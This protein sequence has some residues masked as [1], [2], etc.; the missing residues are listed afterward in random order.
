MKRKSKPEVI[1]SK[2]RVLQG[3]SICEA[4]IWYNQGAVLVVAD[5]SIHTKTV[6]LGKDKVAVVSCVEAADDAEV[7]APEG[8][9]P[10]A[11]EAPAMPNVPE[12]STQEE[13]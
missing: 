4:G 3:C 6:P 11:V 13:V 9:L 10:I 2:V 1:M 8:I 12:P 7:N 5:A